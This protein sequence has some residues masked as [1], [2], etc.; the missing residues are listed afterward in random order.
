[1]TSDS[2]ILRPAARV[3][4]IDEQDRVLLLRANVGMGDVWI[5]PGGALEPGETAEQAALRE[6]RE[7]TGVESAELSRCVWTRVHRFEWGGKRYEQQERFFVA[8]TTAPE[9]CLD[10][11]GPEELQFLSEWRWWTTEETAQSTALFAPRALAKILPAII[12][13][14]YPDEPLALDS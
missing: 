8:R 1:M 12:A 13:G 6:L 14:E 4:L 10:G 3:L 7:E 9:V 5:T 11:C 2:P